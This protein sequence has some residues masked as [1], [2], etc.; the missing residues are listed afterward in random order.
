MGCDDDNDDGDDEIDS[1]DDF[2]P[3]SISGGEGEP[4]IDITEAVLEDVVELKRH[5]IMTDS[6]VEDGVATIRVY[7]PGA[8]NEFGHVRLMRRTDTGL[9]YCEG[10]EHSFPVKDIPKD[11]EPDE[12]YYL[13]GVT[14]SLRARDVTVVMEY[15]VVQHGAYNWF[16]I[17]RDVMWGNI[18]KMDLDVCRLDNSPGPVVPDVPAHRLVHEGRR[19]SGCL[20]R[21]RGM[22]N[23]GL[24]ADR[25]PTDGRFSEV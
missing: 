11:S 25:W 4:D 6:K 24:K 21:Y 23:P 20:S 10:N 2:I 15:D 13:Q 16:K 12:T 18:L 5:Q 22:H 3:F 8:G 9:Q 19:R 17:V 14:P 1:E 7:S